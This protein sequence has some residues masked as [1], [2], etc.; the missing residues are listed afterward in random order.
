MVLPEL[1]S[2]LSG[3]RRGGGSRGSAEHQAVLNSTANHLQQ[4]QWQL[5]MERQNAARDHFS[6]I[7]RRSYGVSN[8]TTHSVSN[9]QGGPSNSS[10]EV[11]QS[12]TV[13]PS[14]AS[15]S[16][17]ASAPSFSVDVLTDSRYVLRKSDF[18]LF[19]NPFRH[20]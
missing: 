10:A 13:T 1:L 12:N 2:Q 8:A 16:S 6:R 5:Q 7:P 18:D 15:V 17:C 9:A 14:V 19:E 4:L 20:T 3:V 11:T